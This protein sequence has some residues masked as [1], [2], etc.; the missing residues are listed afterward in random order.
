MPDAG[1]AS[2]IYN[3]MGHKNQSHGIRAATREVCNATR[4]LGEG[5][6]LFLHQ[7]VRGSVRAVRAVRNTRVF[8][9]ETKFVADG[10][11]LHT[12]SFLA[13]GLTRSV[14]DLMD[15]SNCVDP[16]HWVVS[17]HLT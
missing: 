4:R 12:L 6:G 11:K 16:Q 2:I 13:F 3:T 15:P 14:Q 9:T 5:S 10:T 7:R 17:Y 1:A 8:L